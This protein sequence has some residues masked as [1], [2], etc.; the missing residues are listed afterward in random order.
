M[1]IFYLFTVAILLFN[2]SLYRNPRVYTLVN[3][4]S[5]WKEHSPTSQGKAVIEFTMS[6]LTTIS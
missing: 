5:C 2:K 1:E 4:W 6:P 3:I